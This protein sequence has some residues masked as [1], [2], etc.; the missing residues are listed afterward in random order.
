MNKLNNLKSNQK[1]IVSNQYLFQKGQVV[2]FLMPN[3]GKLKGEVL[4]T[5]FTAQSGYT[6]ALMVN[7]KV[8]YIN[9]KFL[10][11]LIQRALA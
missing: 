9:E 10:Q 8:M 1:S 11:K 3:I 6:V 5:E 4:G 2:T 7:A